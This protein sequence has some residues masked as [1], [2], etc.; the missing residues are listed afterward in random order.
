MPDW[1]PFWTEEIQIENGG[2]YPLLLNRFHDHLEAYLIKGIVS[3]TDRLRYISYCC[4]AIG[5][6]ENSMHCKKYYEFEEAFRRREGA[7]AIGTYLLKPETVMGNYT[8]YGRDVMRGVVEDVTTIYR[9]SFKVLPSNDLGAFGQY[10]KGTMQ[11]WG[12]TS[13]DEDGIIRLT[14]LGTELYKIMSDSYG[15][16]SYHANYKGQNKVPGQVLYD[17]AMLN[18]YDHITDKD[19]KAER[20]FYKSILFHLDTEEVLDGRRDSLTIYLEC[21]GEL[22]KNKCRFDEDKLRN[23]L[24]YQKYIDDDGNLH[25]Y[26]VSSFLQSTR[27]IWMIYEMHDYFGWW[28]SE[29]FRAFLR[30]LSGSA[31]GLSIKEIIASIDKFTFNKTITIFL[32]EN[33]NYYDLEFGDFINKVIEVYDDAWLF[34]DNICYDSWDGKISNF[35]EVSAG[36]LMIISLLSQ[37]IDSIQNDSRYMSIRIKFSEDFWFKDIFDI[38]KIIRGKSIEE[39]LEIILSQF[40]IRQ[41]NN[42]MFEKKDLRRCWFTQCGDKYLYHSDANGIWR[43]AKHNI[44]CNFFYDM[45]LLQVKEG[46]FVLS[47]EGKDLYK[48]LN[49]D[50]YEK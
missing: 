37:K 35:S 15:N 18:Q 24:Y 41:H 38:L 40:V 19:N 33:K 5:D 36:L 4:W 12:L 42:A 26:P 20:D 43:P 29:Y 2:R 17:W 11:N 50:Y 39:V 6:I 13:I 32:K 31:N 16:N 21:L 1:N 27:F 44:I 49:D 10:Y 3:V 45:G 34:E 28:V 46:T 48:K 7:L 9:T 14:E 22:E 47:Q 30:L 23:I 8:T 25:D